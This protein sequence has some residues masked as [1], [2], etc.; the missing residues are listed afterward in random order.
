[1]TRRSRSMRLPRSARRRLRISTG[2]SSSLPKSLRERRPMM[3]QR[4]WRSLRSPRTTCPDHLRSFPW[5]PTR[6]L[7]SQP[8]T[9][10]K[11][12]G[13]VSRL[14][15]PRPKLPL[16][17]PQALLQR[18]M[19]LSS[20]STRTT[21][22]LLESRPSRRCPSR[23]CLNPRQCRGRRHPGSMWRRTGP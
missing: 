3:M 11:L 10:P 5:M 19:M 17:L 16:R 23:R 15:L 12:P 1:M 9:C 4:T 6:S 18:R 2:S 22:S 8:R 14:L 21:A 13:K 7:K 20:M